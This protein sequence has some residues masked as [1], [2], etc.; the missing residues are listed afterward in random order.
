M[1]QK[2]N[3]LSAKSD[4]LNIIRGIYMVEGQ[5]QQNCPLD[6]HREEKKHTDSDSKTETGGISKW[7]RKRIKKRR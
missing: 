1:A 7:R 4:N 6:D 3:V 5:N 2:V